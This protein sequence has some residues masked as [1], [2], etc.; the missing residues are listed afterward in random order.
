MRSHNTL[1]RA[2]KAAATATLRLRL[3]HDNNGGRQIYRGDYL[4]DFFFT[5]L[6]YLQLIHKLHQN[7]Q[8]GNLVQSGAS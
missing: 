5:N 6:K 1:R 3:L 8:N 7:T 4:G 2:L